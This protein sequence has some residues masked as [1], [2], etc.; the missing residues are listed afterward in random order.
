[1]VDETMQISTEKMSNDEFD[2]LMDDFLGMV[3]ETMRWKAEEY[4][5]EDDDR[6]K[7]FRQVAAVTGMTP[8]EVCITYQLKHLHSLLNATRNGNIDWTYA[9]D[10][11]AKERNRAS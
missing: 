7:N 1:M 8:A 9:N 11:G 3:D 10:E 2:E 6:L 5:P 4:S